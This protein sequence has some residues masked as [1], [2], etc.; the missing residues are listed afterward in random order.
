MMDFIEFEENMKKGKV[1]NCY[2]MYGLEEE[3]IKKDI[4][5]LCKKVLNP[6]FM[7]FNYIRFDGLNVEEEELINACETLPFMDEKK[8]VVV[9]RAE[10]LRDGK[11]KK[12]NESEEEEEELKAP[13][14][15]GTQRDRV[16]KALTSYIDKL[17]PHCILIM[18]YIISSKREKL[19]SRITKLGKMADVVGSI[20]VRGDVLEK[21]ARQLFEEYG[22][23]IGAVE[24]KYFCQ[25]MEDK[26][27]MLTLEVEKLCSYTMGRPIKKEDINALLP[28]ETDRDIFDFVDALAEKSLSRSLDIVNELLY[29]GNKIPSILRMIERQFNLLIQI[30]KSVSRGK[31]KE[32]I[33]KELGLHPFVC[34][35]MIEQSRKFSE[36]S[37]GDCIDECLNSEEALKSS[38]IHGAT[39]L[40]LLIVSC[41]TS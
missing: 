32:V 24:L 35:K 41:I 5:I 28:P 25:E 9:Y 38:S 27:P 15:T 2:I 6:Q 31:S 30:K 16:Y 19:S 18:Y 34:G 22:G 1:S 8:V 10:F 36:K 17:P 4:S 11:E 12:T 23:Q 3:Q 33:A 20:K 40:E 21:R 37:L 7:D 39:Q 26:L 29:K 14:K 13:P